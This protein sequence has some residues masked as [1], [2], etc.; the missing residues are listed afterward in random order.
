MTTSITFQQRTIAD[1]LADVS[2][3]DARHRVGVFIDWMHDTHGALA[4]A[5]SGGLPRLPARRARTGPRQ[6]RRPPV[7]RA[8]ALQALLRDNALREQLYALSAAAGGQNIGQRPQG[9][10]R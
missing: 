1:L 7:D 2:N 5:R 6:R 8:R 3:K 10:R 9:V 4:P